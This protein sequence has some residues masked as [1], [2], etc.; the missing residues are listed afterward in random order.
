MSAV[1]PFRI[2]PMAEDDLDGVCALENELAAFPW[3][4]G[5]FADC[6]NAGYSGWVLKLDQLIAAY[7]VLMMVVDEG[8]LLN[9]GVAPSFQRQGLGGRLLEHLMARTRDSGGHSL[10]LEVRPSNTPALELYRRF[11][12]G[13]IGRR[14]AYYPAHL[15]REDALVLRRGLD[16]QT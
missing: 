12:F 6:L 4:R 5:H 2:E 9:I 16:E 14:K 10:M 11:G 1:L 3:T 13:E 7:A 15:G 8:H